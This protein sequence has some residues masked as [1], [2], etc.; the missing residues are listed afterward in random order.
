MIRIPFACAGV[1]SSTNGKASNNGNEEAMPDSRACQ[2]TRIIYTHYANDNLR[3]IFRFFF[4][5]IFRLICVA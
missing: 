4:L 2:H 5:F 1:D 3:N